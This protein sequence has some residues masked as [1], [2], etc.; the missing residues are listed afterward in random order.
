MKK[1]FISMKFR[2]TPAMLAM[3]VAILIGAAVNFSQFLTVGN[4]YN[5]IRQFVTNAILALG[6]SFVIISG[7]IDLSVSTNLVMASFLAMRLI[8]VSFA[9]AVAA[10]LIFGLTAGFVNGL[11]ITKVNF[12]PMIA[13]YST[14][15]L[16]KGI[17]L[18]LTGGST[19]NPLVV[20]PAIRYLGFGDVFGAIPFSLIF[21]LVIF[22]I[23]A[24]LIN[25]IPLVRN[26]YA[27]GANEEAAKMMGVNVVQTKLVAHILCAVLASIAGI[28]VAAR[29]G[30]AVTAA[31]DGYDMLAVASVVIG[32]T[33]MSGGRGKLS[34][35]IL[36]ALVVST[37]SNIFKLQQFLNVYWERAIIGLVLLIVLLFQVAGEHGMGRLTLS[38]P[39]KRHKGE[40]ALQ[41]GTDK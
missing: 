27:V 31:G 26:V 39:K 24:F 11:L 30:A 15:M 33:M 7:S 17:V 28:N 5:I 4:A 32:G 12:P 3:L 41:G 19:Y 14:Q 34:S 25:R 10:A 9:L 13:T 29:T 16:I 22:A 8:H 36:G 20:H 23:C 21:F 35:S 1:Q 37:V 6:M 2:L 18:V 38:D 40:N